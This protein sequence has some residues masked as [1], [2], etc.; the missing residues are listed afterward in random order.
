MSALVLALLTPVHAAQSHNAADYSGSYDLT[1]EEAS[2]TLHLDLAWSVAG[3]TGSSA[4][5]ID[6]ALDCDGVDSTDWQAIHDDVQA[7]C[8]SAWPV[9]DDCD[10]LGTAAADAVAAFND[11]TLEFVPESVDYTVYGTWNFWYRLFGIY[12]VLG[13]HHFPSGSTLS[14]WYLLNNNDG[15]TLGDLAT[16]SMS[17][18]GASGGGYWACADV[19]LGAVEGNLDPDDGYAMAARF[20]VDRSAVCGV[21]DGVDAIVAVLGLTFDGELSGVRQ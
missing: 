5:A 11:G 7:A 17:L 19:S 6:V 8:D 21:S 14:W 10:D 18:N 16:F 20:G 9:A 1:C 3:S 15:G 4:G 12:P 13:D 2:L